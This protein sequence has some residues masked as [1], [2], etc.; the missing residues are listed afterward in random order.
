MSG[1]GWNMLQ[2]SLEGGNQHRMES[3]GSEC[4]K[5]EKLHWREIQEGLSVFSHWITAKPLSCAY[6][7]AQKTG[8]HSW[9]KSRSWGWRARKEKELEAAGW[10]SRVGRSVC[11]SSNWA[12]LFLHS[13]LPLLP[14]STDS[15]RSKNC[16]LIH[17]TSPLW[18]FSSHCR[19]SQ[20]HRSPSPHPGSPESPPWPWNLQ[21]SHRKVGGGRQRL[22]IKSL[23]VCNSQTKAAPVVPGNKKSS[24]WIW[25]T[26]LSFFFFFCDATRWRFYCEE[27]FAKG[28]GKE[29]SERSAGSVF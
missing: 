4:K 18:W 11:A 23:E 1:C 26:V 24:G 19:T 22:N 20:S 29:R 13:R 7:S 8:T 27:W 25:R 6:K 9:G 2:G 21:G 16:P 14:I 12:Q 5:Q 3:V 28:R 15:Q 10:G 17:P